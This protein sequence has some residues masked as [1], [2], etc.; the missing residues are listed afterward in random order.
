MKDW[1]GLDECVDVLEFVEVVV[2]ET[3]ILE[4]PE[5]RAEP[6][7]DTDTVDVVELDWLSVSI[8]ELDGFAELDTDSLEDTEELCSLVKEARGVPEALDVVDGLDEW[9]I[10][11]VSLYETELSIVMLGV[12]VE[13][14][15]PLNVSVGLTV[16]VTPVGKV[17]IL[18]VHVYKLDVVTECE[19]VT[20]ME[21]VLG[22]D[23]VADCDFVNRPEA[24]TVYDIRVVDVPLSLD[25]IVLEDDGDLL[26][27]EEGV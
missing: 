20:V 19:L 8:E 23:R 16:C 24:D 26:P 18:G 11:E 3:D 4:D 15:N 2:C 27:L 14:S 10:L 6:V 9:E 13:E 25:V 7:C 22:G 12:F 5:G 1:L 17:V 21:C